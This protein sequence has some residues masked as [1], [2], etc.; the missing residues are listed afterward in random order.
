VIAPILPGFALIPFVDSKHP[1]TFP[2]VIP[3]THFSGFNL[4]LASRIF[5]KV[6]AKSEI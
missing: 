2:L 1:K 5:V 4:S 3:N 6:S